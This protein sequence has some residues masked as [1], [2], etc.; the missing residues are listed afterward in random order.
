MA[1]L[2]PA[3]ARPTTDEGLRVLVLDRVADL[4][5]HR[6]SWATLAAEAAEPN[7]FYEPWVLLPAIA[8]FNPSL[9]LVLVLAPDGGLRGLFPL[10]R[11]EAVRLP[12]LRLWVHDY[13][14]VP[15]P[16][17]HRDHG[18]A[19]M[20]A[21]FDWL[22]TQP[23]VLALD[24][25]PIDG[26]F[27]GLLMAEVTRRGWFAFVRDHFTRALLHPTCDAETYQARA[28]ASKH[29]RELAR[30]R[31]RMAD[32]G[33]VALTAL[34]P[35][36]DLEPWLDEFLAL[37]ASGWKGRA[38]TALGSKPLDAAY[39]RE[40]ARGCHRAGR[41]SGTALRLDG[42]AVAMQVMLSSGPIAHAF[43]IAYD[44][45]LARFSPGVLLALDLVERTANARGAVDSSAVR[46]HAM[47]NGLWTERRTIQ[48]L[49]IAGRGTAGLLVALLP[50]LRFV[51]G[52]VRRSLGRSS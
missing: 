9:Q 51:R 31:R 27:A 36:D 10:Q 26:P 4:E 48:S 21:F 25:L 18:P 13:G 15:T 5:P 14:Y 19:V 1:G 47:V 6:A 38:G 17:V 46:D 37:E 7:V 11:G 28:M 2:T 44:E 22:A 50:A 29:R 42:R 8:S 35:H 3:V 34:E 40:M 41:L 32:L 12:S 43:K 39:F 45:A 33:A 23:R 24:D 49:L 52:A 30:R 20:S 16:L